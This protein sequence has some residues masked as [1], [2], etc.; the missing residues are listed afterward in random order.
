MLCVTKHFQNWTQIFS[1]GFHGVARVWEGVGL[2]PTKGLVA[3][4]G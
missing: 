4:P 2:K 1:E 3:H